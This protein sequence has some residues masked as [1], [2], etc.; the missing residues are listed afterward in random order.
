MIFFLLF[1][2][3]LLVLSGSITGPDRVA[4][5]RLYLTVL[6]R[7]TER[8]MTVVYDLRALAHE[9]SVMDNALFAETRIPELVSEFIDAKIKAEEVCDDAIAKSYAGTN[10]FVVSSFLEVIRSV[11]AWLELVVDVLAD[12][13]I[14]TTE[15]AT[16]EEVFA[17]LYKDW[18]ELRF[19]VSEFIM[20]SNF[21]DM[22]GSGNKPAGVK[23]PISQEHLVLTQSIDVELPEIMTLLDD[24]DVSGTE[25]DILHA[26]NNL[27]ESAVVHIKSLRPLVQ[28]IICIGTCQPRFTADL[29]KIASLLSALKDD[30]KRII[31]ILP[32]SRDD[33]GTRIL[34]SVRKKLQ[35]K[36]HSVA[37]FLERTL[38]LKSQL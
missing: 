14:E 25:Y 23:L 16:I 1:V 9:D 20:V 13:P 18:Y 3:P 5:G 12:L 24:F 28:P 15:L 2:Q 26:N 4:E 6:E 30:L 27:F 7:L 37:L 21:L 19:E 34:Y 38:R 22:T 8:T 31:E 36:V 17:V 33:P 29:P 35:V 10:A 11:N 32:S